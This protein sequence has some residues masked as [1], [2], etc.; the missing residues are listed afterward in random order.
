MDEVGTILKVDG[1]KAT[2][3]INRHAACGD[4]GA[5]HVGKEKM[6]METEA[7]NNIGAKPGDNVVVHMK[8]MNVLQAVSIAYGIPFICFMIGMFTGWFLGS[9]FNIDNVVSAFSLGLILVIISYLVIYILEKKHV[10]NLKYS[11]QIIGFNKE[12]DHEDK[13]IQ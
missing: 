1:N 11:P 5:C 12:I 4:C 3:K 9:Y 13:T 6:T 10:F 2:V 7:D 8:F